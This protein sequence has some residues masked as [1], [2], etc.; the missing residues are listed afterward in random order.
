MSARIL[1]VDDEESVRSALRVLLMSE[2]YSVLEAADGL[3]ATKLLHEQTI[4]LA[5]VDLLMPEQDGLE[6][7]LQMH[8]LWPQVKIIAISGGGRYGLMHLLQVAKTFGA[9]Q[10]LP[11]PFDRQ[12]LLMTI[13]EVLGG[14]ES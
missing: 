11:K 3:I 10:I 7:I 2:G 12:G 6:T 5:I 4:D 1:I 9:N 13:C 14:A 8:R